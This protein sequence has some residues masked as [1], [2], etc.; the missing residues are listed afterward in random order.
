MRVGALRA[1]PAALP[2]SRRRRAGGVLAARGDA[3]GHPAQGLL[4]ELGAEIYEE[5]SAAGWQFSSGVCNDKSIGAVDEVHGLEDAGAAA[6]EAV[7]ADA[8]RPRRHQP[9]GRRRAARQRPLRRADRRARRL[10][11]SSSGP[12]RTP[13]STCGGASACP[14]AQFALHASDDL[15]AVTTTD[16][17]FGVRAAVVLKLLPRGDAPAGPG[18]P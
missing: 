12:T 11:R 10:H 16:T 5:A 18:Q 1:D 14:S 15:V 7:R 4:P 6:G 17:R 8:H 9:R 2:R 13:P 3:L